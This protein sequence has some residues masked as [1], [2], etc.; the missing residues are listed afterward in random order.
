MSDVE[1]TTTL[2][3]VLYFKGLA[4]QELDFHA[5][6]GELVDN[7]FSA[8][9]EKFGTLTNTTIEI[10][11]T[12]L[13]DGNVRLTIA[14]PGIGIPFEDVTSKVFNLGGQ[15]ASRG[16]LNEHGFGLKNALALLTGGNATSFELITRSAKDANLG[17]DQF[18][19]VEGP[20]STSMKVSDGATRS[21]WGQSL[22]VLGPAA[23]GTKISVV[24]P[25]NYFRTLYRRGNPGLDVLVTRLGEH[26][27]VMH[28][29]FLKDNKILISYQAYGG[30]VIHRTVQPI[31]VPF[32]GE[33]KT[34]SRDIVVGGK[35]HKFTYRR[36]TLDYSV[37][38]PEAEEEKGWP[39]PLRSYYQGSN[40]RCGVDIVVRD[41]IIKTG[42][43]EDIWTDIAKTVDFNRF[44]GEL[45][46]GEDFRTTNN[47]TGLDPHAENWEQ[48]LKELGEVEFRPEKATRSD[49][50]K[51]LQDR[52]VHILKGTFSGASVVHERKVWAGTV[53]I[54]I[55]VDGGP[56]NR[57]VYELKVTS[58]RVV[59][60]YQLLAGW[61]GLV[62][63]GVQPTIGILVVKDY[64]QTLQ[65]AVAEANSRSD[66]NGS[67]YNIELRTIQELVPPL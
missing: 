41:R 49:S 46:V 62:R 34:I 54:D 16:Q 5:A 42:V 45:R 36:G 58:G 28:R 52:L 27:G 60:L 26:L 30:D 57:R 61:D 48:L 47:K 59:D 37:K 65:D 7:A 56:A 11:I 20:L 67:I 23:T 19:R 13:A 14:D 24:V 12:Q 9:E 33:E 8:R 55:F 40:A 6:L 38:D 21:D 3:P 32:E 17:P 18:L 29:Y 31:P 63:E 15:G 53:S 22:S 35:V 25:W 50:E 1:F 4:R 44:V 2:D 39:Y 10:N 64:S 66:K 43:F 51:S